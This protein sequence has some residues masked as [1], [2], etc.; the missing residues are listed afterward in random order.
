[1]TDV[2]RFRADIQGLRAV[3]VLVVVAFHAGL[4]LPGG[5]VGVDVFFVISGFVITGMLVADQERTGRVD[6][7][8]FYLRRVRRLLPALAV[9]VGVVLVLGP[10]LGPRSAAT[11][12]VRTARAGTLFGANVQLLADAQGYFDAG[13]EANAFLHLWTLSVE[14]QFYL[15]F[16]LL[17][18]LAG[19]LGAGRPGV[20]RL[21]LGAFAL[22]SF[23]LAA[24]LAGGHMPGIEASGVRI[25]FYSAPTRAWE[26]LAGC[27]L[28]LVAAR[29]WSP[30]RAVADTCGGVG[31]LLLAGS[32][33][34]LD[35]STSFPWP[36]G[37]V[38]VAAAVLLLA[39]GVG[40]GGRVSRGLSVAPARWLGDRSYG[41]YLWHWP[42]I[43]FARSLFPSAGWAPPV[44]AVLALGPTVWS[45]RWVEQPIRHR[46]PRVRPTLALGAACLAVPLLLTATVAPLGTALDREPEIVALNRQLGRHLDQTRGCVDGGPAP[47]HPDGCTWP[48]PSPAAGRVVLLGDS[49]A[50]H[51]AE[52]FVTAAGA[53]GFDAAIATRNGCPFADVE[54]RRNGVVDDRCH[55]FYRD[56]LASLARD[57]PDAVVLASATDLRVVESTSALRAA[58]RGPW[59]TDVDAKLAVWQA[60]LA[61]TVAELDE[62][63]IGVVVVSPV[64][65][66]TGWQPLGQCARLRIVVD[67][68]GCGEERATADTRPLGNRFRDAELAA[69]AGRPRATVLDLGP[70]LCPEPR[71]RTEVDGRWVFRDESHITVATSTEVAPYVA[72]ALGA[73]TGPAAG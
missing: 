63:G 64:P 8:R 35:G 37:V 57:R 4:A 23:A 32:V 30:A 59:A 11:A 60:G 66:F 12:T 33:V 22:V 72:E 62:L 29:G 48:A 21:V 52:G 17:L 28:A 15:G 5:F 73:V 61:R 67:A 14:E 45:H 38:P 24:A 25:A 13:P 34:L 46:P 70:A 16:P 49:N 71:C 65:R 47:T 20:R 56:Q 26:F 42:L 1:M 3:A 36:V 41:W 40:D 19:R 53:L 2:G 7:G 69:V 44:A 9:M 68:S 54:L 31:A 18:L 43:V 51:L 58:G 6:L 50:G 27:L 55:R 10:L 39:A